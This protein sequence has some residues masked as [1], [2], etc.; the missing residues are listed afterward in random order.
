[1][2]TAEVPTAEV[3]TAEVATVG[4]PTVGVP[5]LGVPGLGVPTAGV[6]AVGRAGA[7]HLRGEDNTLVR[8]YVL[9]HEPGEGA[10]RQRARRRALWCAVHGIDAGP[11]IIHGV[12]VTA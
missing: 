8:P 11:R 12:E 7:H 10:G 2:P 5:G 3:P 9:A 6:P 1:M 4:V